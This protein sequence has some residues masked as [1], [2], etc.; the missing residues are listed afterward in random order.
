MSDFHLPGSS[1]RGRVTIKLR[2]A[3]LGRGIETTK[4]FKC[5]KNAPKMRFENALPPAGPFTKRKRM[6]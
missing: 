2:A 5:R 6:S 4:S 3:A 1:L